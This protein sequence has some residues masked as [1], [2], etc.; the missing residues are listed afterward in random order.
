MLIS[1]SQNSQRCLWVCICTPITNSSTTIGAIADPFD[2]DLT[3]KLPDEMLF[4]YVNRKYQRKI[5]HMYFGE[6]A[7][8]Y[9]MHPFRYKNVSLI[10][11]G[12]SFIYRWK[13]SVLPSEI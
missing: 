13:L 2:D 3:Y 7:E 10:M 1:I 11:K 8:F 4:Q 5:N 6:Y 12:I 9:F